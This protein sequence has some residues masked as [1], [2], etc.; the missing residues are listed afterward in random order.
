MCSADPKAPPGDLGRTGHCA[1]TLPQARYLHLRGVLVCRRASLA[2]LQA[3]QA[4]EE[5]TL[6]VV[7]QRLRTIPS[8]SDLFATCQ[9]VRSH[10][11]GKN[12]ARHESSSAAGWRSCYNRKQ[13]LATSLKVLQYY[14]AICV[15]SAGHVHTCP[16]NSHMICA[17][18]ANT[19]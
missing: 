1:L 19:L 9:F 13:Q 2:T 10:L 8:L 6:V 5:I 7:P 11:L 12:L 14:N 18:S 4:S 16:H 17:W 15:H 3:L